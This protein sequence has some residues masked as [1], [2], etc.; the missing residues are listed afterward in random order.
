MLWIN[1]KWFLQSI[2]DGGIGFDD[3]FFAYIKSELDTLEEK[4]QDI[5]NQG[6]E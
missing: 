2:K 5:D 4:H 6:N 1:G 3:D